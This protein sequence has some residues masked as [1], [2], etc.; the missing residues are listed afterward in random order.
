MAQQKE[1]K[2]EDMFKQYNEATQSIRH[3]SGLRFVIFTVFFA[4]VGGLITLLG[5]QLPYIVFSAKI[6]GIIG[7]FVFWIYEYRLSG[8]INHYEQCIFRLEED[9]GYKVHIGRDIK[10]LN[11]RFINIRNVTWFMYLSIFIFWILSFAK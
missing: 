8:Y 11:T 5:N 7:T 10:I 4:Y 1:T 9:L 2:Q 6:G 3:Y